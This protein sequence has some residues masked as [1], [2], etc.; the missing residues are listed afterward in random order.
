MIRLR[1]FW[2]LALLALAFAV[3]QHAAQLHDLGHAVQT[4]HSDSKDFHPGSVQCDKCF[5]YAQLG[6]GA[7]AHVPVLPAVFVASPEFSVSSTPAQSRTV[8]YARSRAPP[9]VL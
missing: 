4:L 5:A 1:R 6:S 7:A 9:Q 2:I 8:I 3:G